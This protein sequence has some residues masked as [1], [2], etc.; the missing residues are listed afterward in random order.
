MYIVITGAGKVGG[1][2]CGDLVKENHDIIVIEKDET[3][4]EQFLNTYDI[5]GVS[6]N[7]ATYGVQMEAGVDRCDVFISVTSNDETNI[8][9]A[10]TARKLGAKYTVARVRSPEYSGQVDFLRESLGIT[11]MINPELEAAKAITQMLQF[12]AA[13]NVEPFGHGRV[14]MV[15]LVLRRDAPMVGLKLKDH[16]RRFGNVIICIVVRGDQVLIPDGETCLRAGDHV[17]VT[18]STA[19]VLEFCN[20]S[21]HGS[22]KLESALMIG[23]GRVTNYLVPELLKM[24]MRVKVIERDPATADELAIKFPRAEIVSGDGTKQAFLKEEHASDYDSLIA[25]TGIDE[26]NILLSI[27][28]QRSGIK[29]TVTKVNRTDLLKVLDNVGLQAVITPQCIISD[30]IVRFIRSA[31]NS[32]GSNIDAFYRLADG[33]V[34]VLQ[35]KVKESSR[36]AKTPLAQLPT[37]SGVLVICILRE[38]KI[39]Y[40]GGSDRIMPGDDVIVA[41]THKGFQDLDDILAETRG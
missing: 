4:L 35:F 33:S 16:N 36:A 11:L 9:A 37:K 39:I 38:N 26:E 41:T 13:L 20:K 12:P 15:E 6:G 3:R 32:Q 1:K 28:A 5:S 19:D 2:L 40:P 18:G 22:A 30:T 14:N 34:E 21:Q 7:G 17:M 24:H 29:K 27:Y 31:E 25:L 23:G 10:I 8:I